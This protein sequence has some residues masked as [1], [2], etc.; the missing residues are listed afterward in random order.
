MKGKI[1]KKTIIIVVV[2]IAVIG[3]LCAFLVPKVV[4]G[5][6]SKK[7]VVTVSTLEKIVNVSELSTFSAVYNGIAK[8]YNSEN[9]DQIDYYVSYDA[10]IKAGID[11][12]KVS[13]DIKDSQD[14]K[15]NVKNVTITIPKV[16]ITKV[17]VDISSLDFIFM[18]DSANKAS[19]SEQAYKA[20]TDD[21]TNESKEQKAIYTLA[22]QNAKS[23]VKALV[24]PILSQ[25]NEEQSEI[26]YELNVVVEE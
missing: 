5:D 17:N 25:L 8:V 24:N 16:H 12:N 1:N 15:S 26:K 14:K 23:V 6:K 20:C 2:V 22:E 10:K 13:I 19:V 3:L 7:E 4:N 11:F 18:N 9:K 21:A